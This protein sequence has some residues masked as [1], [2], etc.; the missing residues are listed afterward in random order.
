MTIGLICTKIGTEVIKMVYR[1]H[2][3]MLAFL[4]DWL[5]QV[6]SFCVGTQQAEYMKNLGWLVNLEKSELIPA[7]NF[8]FLGSGGP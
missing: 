7:Q 5:H 6:T 8:I 2:I 4:D 1:Q 3:E